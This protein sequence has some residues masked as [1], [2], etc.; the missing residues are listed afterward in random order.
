MIGVHE[1]RER[2]RHVEG[3]RAAAACLTSATASLIHFAV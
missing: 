1:Q 2:R 3:A